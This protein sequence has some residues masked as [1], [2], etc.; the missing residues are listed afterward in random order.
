MSITH[1]WYIERFD[2]LGHSHCVL[3]RDRVLAI[4]DLQGA[5]ARQ[6]LQPVRA[7]HALCLALSVGEQG[8]TA[9]LTRGTPERASE[10]VSQIQTGDIAWQR[11]QIGW[12]WGM[13]LQLHP[14]PDVQQWARRLRRLLSKPY[15]QT[16]LAHVVIDD[17]LN[18]HFLDMTQQE[19]YHDRLQRLNVD[20]IDIRKPHSWRVV[21]A[22]S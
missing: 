1:H 2:T 15:A 12:A 3:S 6:I 20:F 22:F 11:Q 4:D 14:H 17:L 21:V 8:H 5:G 7:N 16:P 13:D 18:I 10:H 19:T 9:A